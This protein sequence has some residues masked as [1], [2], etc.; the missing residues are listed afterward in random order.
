MGDDT[1]AARLLD[2][3]AEAQLN[4]AERGALADELARA[5]D[6]RQTLR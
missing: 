5:D 3:V 4:A 2:E 1:L 6:L